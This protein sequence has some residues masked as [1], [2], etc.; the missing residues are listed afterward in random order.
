MTAAPV[1]ESSLAWCCGPRTPK[2]KP[3]AELSREGGS[4]GSFFPSRIYSKVSV[5]LAAHVQL[6]A[7]RR[8]IQWGSGSG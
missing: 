6:Y 1:E 3:G 4:N 2:A 8:Q 5:Y 7:R